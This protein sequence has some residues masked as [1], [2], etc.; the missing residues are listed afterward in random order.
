MRRACAKSG[1]MRAP[2]ATSARFC[3]TG[4]Y[5]T[6][7]D[8]GKT[9]LIAATKA[10]RVGEEDGRATNAKPA[11]PLAFSEAASLRIKSRT[12]E[13]EITEPLEPMEVCA[14]SGS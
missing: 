1:K 8:C 6:K 10:A 9:S 5:S 13:T 14:R 4:V 3:A 2:R 7:R 12:S 11:P